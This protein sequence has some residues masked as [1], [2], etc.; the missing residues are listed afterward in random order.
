MNR[1]LEG[2]EC[3]LGKVF[4]SREALAGARDISI[5]GIWD[6]TTKGFSILDTDVAIDMFGKCVYEYDHDWEGAWA[7]LKQI[8]E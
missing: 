4:I 2:K 5:Q 6:A 3:V 7:R 8:S 1:A